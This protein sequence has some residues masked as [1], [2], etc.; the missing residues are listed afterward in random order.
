MDSI[1]QI[2]T[3]L[4]DLQPSTTKNTSPADGDTAPFL[5]AIDQ[6]V[7]AVD[8]ESKATAQAAIQKSKAT[9]EISSQHQQK[10]AFLSSQVNQAEV[11]L[12]SMEG[13][14]Q[15]PADIQHANQ[16]INFKRQEVIYWQTRL[17]EAGT[18]SDE[19]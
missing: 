19:S 6:L 15:S 8:R 9:Q 3:L 11:A 10:I 14:Q 2:S 16:L 17:E 4:S 5:Q 18:S 1:N 12:S 7:A 13:T